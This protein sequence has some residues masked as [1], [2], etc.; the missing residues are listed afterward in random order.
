MSA[1][2][3]RRAWILRPTVVPEWYAVVASLIP[4]DHYTVAESE[5]DRN[6]RMSNSVDS[7]EF[8]VDGKTLRCEKC[9]YFLVPEC[10]VSIAWIVHEHTFSGPAV[11]YGSRKPRE[12]YAVCDEILTKKQLQDKLASL[13]PKGNTHGSA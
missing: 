8:A 13:R 3:H 10:K 7:F 2:K 4:L 9:G 12:G 5:M 1:V 11:R 6:E